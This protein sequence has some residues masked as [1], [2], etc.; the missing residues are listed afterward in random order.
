MITPKVPAMTRGR[1]KAVRSMIGAVNNAATAARRARDKAREKHDP[2]SDEYA[3][4]KAR[5]EEAE[6]LMKV[7]HWRLDLRLKELEGPFRKGVE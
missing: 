5:Y 2:F 7:L 3:M 4:E 6:E 1:I